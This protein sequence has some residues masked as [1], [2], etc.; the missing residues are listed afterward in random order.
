MHK[1]NSKAKVYEH[2]L[3]VLYLLERVAALGI[4]SRDDYEAKNAEILA[5]DLYGTDKLTRILNETLDTIVRINNTC[6]EKNS[7]AELE[8][9]F[10]D[11][12]SILS[13]AMRKDLGYKNM[14]N[15]PTTLSD[16]DFID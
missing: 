14:K 3:K 4:L 8:K 16:L 6:K 9:D 5:F 10:F 1:I 11:Q 12:L 15:D 7:I 13:K 2:I